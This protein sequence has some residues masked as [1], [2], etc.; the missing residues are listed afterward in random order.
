LRIS[1]R[2]S[3]SSLS[4]RWFTRMV[5]T[6][7]CAQKNSQELFKTSYCEIIQISIQSQSKFTVA[8]CL[9]RY[10][11]ITQQPR[12][13]LFNSTTLLSHT[14]PTKIKTPHPW[15]RGRAVQKT[16]A[17]Y[18]KSVAWH[19]YTAAIL[20]WSIY[21]WLSVDFRRCKA[22]GQLTARRIRI[23]VRLRCT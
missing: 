20:S 16:S 7:R 5:A 2:T 6:K 8:A 21:T 1:L 9:T 4:P 10:C 17:V 22:D 3:L 23:A 14:Y 18:A 19:F 15:S 11:S 13:S 12:F